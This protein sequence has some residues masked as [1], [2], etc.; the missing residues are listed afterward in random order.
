[1]SIGYPFI[2]PPPLMVPRKAATSSPEFRW[3]VP[4][5]FKATHLSCMVHGS[6]LQLD[7]ATDKEV[8]AWLEKHGKCNAEMM[9]RGWW[10]RKPTWRR[11]W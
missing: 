9:E 4:K 3:D 7:D 1:M 10:W 8:E 2:A 11:R 5:G 6:R